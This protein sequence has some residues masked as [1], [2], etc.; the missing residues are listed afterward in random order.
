MWLLGLLLLPLLAQ[1]EQFIGK[2]VGV[3]TGDQLS[4]L[5]NGRIV[6]VHLYGIACPERS[7]AFGAQARQFTR[8]LTLRRTVAVVVDAV[9]T[10]A[11]RRRGQ[12]IAAVELPNG[13][14]LSQVLVRAGYA[15]HDTRYAPHDKSL[16]QLQAEARSTQRGLWVDT[17]PIPPW[18]WDQGQRQP[19]SPEGPQGTGASQAVII[20]N[21]RGKIYYWPGCPEYDKVS[22][23]NRVRFQDREAAEQAGYRP[24]ENCQ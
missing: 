20:G 7:Q 5:R 4:V 3:R 19:A 14:D 13:L 18:E 12:L 9:A 17:N 1:A 6:Q 11:T 16:A 15:W 10:D 21:R 8:D 24:A 22:R 2:V 23:R